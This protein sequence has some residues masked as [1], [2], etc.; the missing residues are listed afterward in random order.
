MLL[1]YRIP[2]DLVKNLEQRSLELNIPLSTKLYRLIFAEGLRS[3]DPLERM[4]LRMQIET[5]C[6]V[7][8]D[9]RTN[10]K[11]LYEAA[12]TDGNELFLKFT[13]PR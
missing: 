11:K 12:M 7:R 6:L 2:Q 13:K 4:M 3:T 5:Y 9:I 8:R 1:Q 10:D